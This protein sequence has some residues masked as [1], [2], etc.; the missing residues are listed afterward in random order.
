[1][2]NYKEKVERIVSESEDMLTA[3]EAI[4]PMYGIPASNMLED[5]NATSL[6]VVNDHII[7]PSGVKP[8]AKS[9]MC[10]IGAVLDHISQRVD[11]KINDCQTQA[12]AKG[13]LEDHIRRD[14]NPAKGKV[15]G[16]YEDSNGDE[17]LAYDSGLVDM[18][19][20]REAQQKVAELRNNMQI[21]M[22]NPAV[23]TA[24]KT[25]SYFTDEDDISVDEPAPM[26]LDDSAVVD[27]A[28]ITKESTQILDWIAHYND[29]THLGYDML[30]EQG[31]DFV[32]MTDAYIQ[33]AAS[34][35]KEIKP[36]DIKHM[37]FDNSHILKAIEYFNKARAEQPNA[38]K[39]EWSIDQFI[40]ST[41]YKKAVDELEKQFDCKLN[42]R[43]FKDNDYPDETSLSTPIM[44]NMKQKMSI[45]KSKGFQ[46]HG[47]P[48]DIFVIN[49]AIDEEMTKKT[50]QSLFGQFVC[51]GLCHE[52]FHNIVSAVR[53]S[54]ATFNFSLM[55]AFSLAT[56]SPSAKTRRVVFEK[57]TKSLE[58][59]G[60]KLNPIQKKKLVRDLCNISAVAYNEQLL[61]KIKGKLAK[62]DSSAAA[63]KEMD[64]YI[65]LLKRMNK[66]YE[67]MKKRSDKIKKHKI[68]YNIICIIG[69]ILTLTVVGMFIGIPLIASTVDPMNDYEEYLKSTNKE[70]FYC[71]LFAGAYNL[72]FTFVMGVKNREF[73]VNQI[74][75]DRIQK[76]A[77]LEKSV[78]QFTR[79]S[80]PTISERNYAAMT[81][82]KNILDSKEKIDPALK[83]YC[84]WVVANY[85]NILDTD[86]GENY[87]SV[88]FNPEE[89]KDLD[90]HI[91]NLIENNDITITE[92]WN[93]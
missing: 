79:S 36:S 73:T 77:E 12:I 21:P 8:N 50:D 5:S 40:N 69:I 58:S 80:Y 30:Q 88:T 7:T 37:K 18:A 86:I 31:F 89:A 20:T 52:I 65:K 2:D 39:G 46:L 27:Y 68:L 19:N 54:T 49:K 16:R 92:S 3:L 75:N 85:S 67:N 47:L 72:P 61:S 42:I 60:V 23:M 35:K 13:K 38:G 14:A 11:E 22:Y 6:K 63:D 55:S 26:T 10:A 59:N 41:N 70:E 24:A 34:S 84:E 48:V 28:S 9:I 76:I 56:S 1:M 15:I 74:S 32:K 81:I 82:A 43:W 64:E 53:Y 90:E 71:D 44:S 62:A 91:Q 29:T 17:I 87:N 25:Y 33:E 51:A 57:F 45:S 78:H 83:E 4:G 66:D 93:M